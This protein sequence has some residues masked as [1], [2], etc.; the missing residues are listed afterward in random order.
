MPEMR[1]GAVW[2][3]RKCGEI[4]AIVTSDGRVW[5][6]AAAIDSYRETPRQRRCVCHKCGR[7]SIWPIRV[8]QRE[9]L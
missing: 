3:C 6:N 2:T 1:K 4:L 9:A 8:C 7:V 5:V